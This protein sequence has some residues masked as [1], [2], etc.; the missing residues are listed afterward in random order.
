M[1]KYHVPSPQ[2]GVEQVFETSRV[3]PR[4][5]MIK[6]FKIWVYKEGEAPLVHNGPMKY[7]YSVEPDEVYD[8]SKQMQAVVK[9]YIDIIAKRYPYWNRSNEADHFYVYCN[10]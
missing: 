10:D 5:E 7:V 6:T 2:W 1:E 8:F 9:D 4:S 3:I